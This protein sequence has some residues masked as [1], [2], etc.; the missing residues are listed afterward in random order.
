VD[1]DSQHG[2]T[3]RLDARGVALQALRVL[4]HEAHGG[5]NGRLPF[6]VFVRRIAERPAPH[7]FGNRVPVGSDACGGVDPAVVG[8]TGQRPVFV[9]GAAA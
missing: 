1:G 4:A 9:D 7:L 3:H 2:D 6:A 5:Q 8:T